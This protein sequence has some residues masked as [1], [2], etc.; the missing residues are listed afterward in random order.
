MARKDHGISL[1]SPR[2]QP[3]SKFTNNRQGFD[4][5]S[6]TYIIDNQYANRIYRVGGPDP[7][8]V[9]PSMYIQ[10]V[11]QNER[12][13]GVIE[14]TLNFEGLIFPE[15]DSGVIR[16]R[17]RSVRAAPAEF[18]LPVRILGSLTRVTYRA[19]EI[20]VTDVLVQDT[21]PNLR[22]IGKKIEP[23]N[24]KAA[25]ELNLSAV[26]GADPADYGWRLE[27][28]Q[29]TEAGLSESSETILYEITEVY[30]FRQ[31]PIRIKALLA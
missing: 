8:G 18:T 23:P 1:T 12:E 30:R 5:G 25:I 19:Y 10:S 26:T 7:E 29:Y 22:D 27:D 11:D 3:G 2:L 15:G 6:R 4:T 24:F 14:F 17:N 16:S 9:Y 13:L 28:I 20:I 31:P 21:A